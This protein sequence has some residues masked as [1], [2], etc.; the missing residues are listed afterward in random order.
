MTT[1]KLSREYTKNKALNSLAFYER[2]SQLERQGYK[3]LGTGSRARVFWREDK[4]DRVIRVAIYDGAEPDASANFGGADGWLEY[5]KSFAGSRSKHFPK[6]YSVKLYAG[7]YEVEME[8]LHKAERMVWNEIQENFN[9]Q[10]PR[11][12]ENFVARV[13]DKREEVARDVDIWEDFHNG[14]FMARANGDIVV[15]DP[16]F[17]E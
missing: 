17:I 2:G 16:W 14:N 12:L 7:F 1:R 13:E 10:P 9:G 8:R 6:V 11:S 3:V 15:T 4:P 5:F